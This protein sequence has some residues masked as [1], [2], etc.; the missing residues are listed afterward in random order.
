MQIRAI[1]NRLRRLERE[2]GDLAEQEIADLTMPELESEI[3]K[4]GHI[5]IMACGGIEA[6][7]ALLREE[8]DEDTALFFMDRLGKAPD[9]YAT[10]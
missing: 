6:A 4:V 8:T 3:Q 1:E 10:H 9:G 5:L 2:A 7:A